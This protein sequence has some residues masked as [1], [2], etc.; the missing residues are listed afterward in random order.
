MQG[1]E[2]PGYPPSQGFPPPVVVYPPKTGMGCGA[3]L[4]ILLGVLFLLLI[5]VCC[6]GFFGFTYWVKNSVTTDANAVRTATEE[7][8]SIDV[9]AALEPAGAMNLHVPMSGRLIMVLV[10][11]ADKGPHKND[12][13]VLIASGE[14]LDEQTQS[15]VREA[16][17]Q[18]LAQQ[19]IQQE[20]QEQLKNRQ[21]SVEERVIR[22]QAA[23]FTIIKGVG[24]N[25][26]RQRIEVQGTFQ[27]KTGAAALMLQADADRISEAD[28]LKMLD[29]IK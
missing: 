2:Q 3:K 14:F 23:R 10:A 15:K 1:S 19:G 5:L 26:G 7:I 8:T 6:G 11:F 20:G 21:S 29:S 12:L 22:G 13:L 16:F 27:G 24:A 28:V 4:L 18:S 9:P 17:Q 25:T